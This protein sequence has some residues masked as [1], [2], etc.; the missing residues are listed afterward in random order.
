[1]GTAAG[2]GHDNALYELNKYLET[3]GVNT[4]KYKPLGINLY[5]GEGRFSFSII[6]QDLN[7]EDNKI[8]SLDF[9]NQQGINDLFVILK[10]LNVILLPSNFN[11]QNYNWTDFHNPKI[12]D[13]RD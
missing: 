11:P 12:I 9:E 4:E 6:C 10:R 13:D 2:D 1:M 5:A 3:K 8:V 7:K